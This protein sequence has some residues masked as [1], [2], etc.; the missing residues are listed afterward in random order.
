M[1]TTQQILEQNPNLLPY[2]VT[3]A[4]EKGDKFTIVFYCEAEDD[5]HAEEQ[6]LNAYPSAEIYNID[7]CYE[8]DTY[9]EYGVNTRNSFNTQPAAN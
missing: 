4:E 9:D 6:A 1:K 7:W 2:R 3:L 5:D 8:D